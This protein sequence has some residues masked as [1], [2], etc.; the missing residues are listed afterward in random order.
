MCQ[1]TGEQIEDSGQHSIFEPFVMGDSSRNSKAAAV[2]ALCTSKIVK[3][4]GAVLC[5][6]SKQ[7]Q[8]LCRK[9]L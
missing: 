1:D 3:M 2:L 6:G 5:H 8:R 4:H 7:V 9:H